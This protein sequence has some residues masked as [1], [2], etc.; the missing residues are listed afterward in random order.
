MNVVYLTGW[1]LAVAVLTAGGCERPPTKEDQA[2]TIRLLNGGLPREQYA[3]LGRLIEMGPE[4]RA[5]KTA[6]VTLIKKR[7]WSDSWGLRWPEPNQR[8]PLPFLL[9]ALKALWA[10]DPGNP[11]ALQYAVDTWVAMVKK[12]RFCTD[13]T[14]KPPFRL[15]IHHGHFW[16]GTVPDDE[17]LALDAALFKSTIAAFFGAHAAGA[18]TRHLADQKANLA[19]EESG[20]S[21]MDMHI[22]LTGPSERRSVIQE[23]TSLLALTGRQPPSRSRVRAGTGSPRTR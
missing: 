20:L 19:T 2:G 5:A 15:E 23:I 11:L 7:D 3:A 8:E 12:E 6:L 1:F 17:A 18:L 13:E 21:D 9:Q 14:T 22:A 16:G 4:G 10:I